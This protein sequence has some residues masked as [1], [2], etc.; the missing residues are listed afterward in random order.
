MDKYIIERVLEEANYML[1]NK[2]TVRD[3]ADIY[4][5]SKSTVHK[6]LQDRLK[7]INMLLHE[8]VDKIFKEHIE[9]RHIRGG[10]STK[11]KYLKL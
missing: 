7:D 6:D 8:E 4:N 3:L 5:V 10:E 11:K 2:S 9:V 1:A